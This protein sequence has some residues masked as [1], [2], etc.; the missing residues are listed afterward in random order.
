[1]SEDVR[2][3]TYQQFMSDD[4]IHTREFKHFV[5]RNL[6]DKIERTRG[7]NFDELGYEERT[8]LKDEVLKATNEQFFAMT[9]EMGREIVK[10]SGILLLEGWD[11]SSA[12]VFDELRKRHDIDLDS[13]DLAQRDKVLSRVLF[14]DHMDQLVIWC[15]VPILA[16]MVFW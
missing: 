9:L 2:L 8:R 4:F 10:R 3:T 7:I 16:D 6:T 15:N 5:I 14:Y 11:I 12:I 1:M 13:M